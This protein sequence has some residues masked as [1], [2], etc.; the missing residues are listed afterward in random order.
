MTTPDLVVL[1]YEQRRHDHDPIIDAA[2]RRG[3]TTELW[4]PGH[5]SVDV[6]GPVTECVRHEGVVAV[7]RYVLPRAVNR[8]LP[9]VAHVLDAWERLG[10]RTVPSASSALVCA[11]KLATARALAAAGVPTVMSVGLLE[12][13]D[14]HPELLAGIDGD[15]LVTKPAFG[16]RGRGVTAYAARDLAAADLV[17]A[18]DTDDHRIEHRVVQPRATSFGRDY[19][20][21][22]AAGEVVACAQRTAAPG[23][24]ITN[25]SG[26]RVMPYR[27]T[28]AEN[29]ALAAA[30]TLGLEFTGIDVIEHR[31]QMMVLEANA[32]PGL[33]VTSRVCGV[34]LAEVLLEVLTAP[35]PDSTPP[36]PRR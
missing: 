17:V 15:A 4:N 2:R 24:F 23:Q 27:H 5:L 16:S 3:L 14:A 8:V 9:F 25:G 28:A 10:V 36:C 19:R 33:T 1:G 20:V 30:H 22:V 6:G 21:I 26:A 11:D 12:G 13:P 7:P 31:G 18:P 35:G 32:W 34:D 29:V